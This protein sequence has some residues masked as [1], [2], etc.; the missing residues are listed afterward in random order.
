MDFYDLRPVGDAGNKPTIK[1]T[2]K[3]VLVT[4][5]NHLLQSAGL[6][7]AGKVRVRFGES[8]KTKAIRITAC[9]DE[10]WGLT[11]RKNVAQIFVRE[12]MPKV[13]VAQAEVAFEIDAG[14]LTLSLPP[15]WDL[16]DPHVVVRDKETHQGGGARPVPSPRSRPP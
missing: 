1:T 13:A 12:I 4:I 11:A 8:G 9:T 15:A 7:G 3:S 10:G 2:D 16:A 14:S 5:P 6:S